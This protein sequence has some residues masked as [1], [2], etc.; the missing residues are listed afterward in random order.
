MNAASRI[1]NSSCSVSLQ[2]LVT[3]LRFT[4]RWNRCRRRFTRPF[5]GVNTL[6]FTAR[7]QLALARTYG[8]AW[9]ESESLGPSPSAA[10]LIYL[11]HYLVNRCQVGSNSLNLDLL[12][13]RIVPSRNIAEPFLSLVIFKPEREKSGYRFNW[14][15]CTYGTTRC[16]ADTLGL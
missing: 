14:G 1:K 13:P 7:L 9:S 10:L 11:V 2:L 6:S 12:R 3:R 15:Q 8:P 16:N 4:V 5:R